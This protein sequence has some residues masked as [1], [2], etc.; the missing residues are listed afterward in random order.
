MILW[1]PF[2]EVG[3]ILIIAPTTGNTGNA[4]ASKTDLILAS[5]SSPKGKELVDILS[6]SNKIDVDN[7]NDSNNRD[8]LAPFKLKE[9]I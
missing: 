8:S 9:T 1:V 5:S 2:A 3:T 6:A 7:N 4:N